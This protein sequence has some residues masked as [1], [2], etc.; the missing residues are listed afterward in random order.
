MPDAAPTAA[1][2]TPTSAGSTP[3]DG[4]GSGQST[5]ERVVALCLHRGFVFRSAEIYGGFRSAYDYGPLGVQLL[6]NIKDQWWRTMVL[7]RREVVGLDAAILSPAAVWEASGHL[8]HFSDPLRQCQNCG[9]RHRGDHLK[10][11][12]TCPDCG[13][14]GAL[15]DARQFNLM[16]STRAGPAADSGAVVYLRPETAQGTYI[17][18]NHVARCVRRPPPFGVAQIGKSFRNE[19]TPGNFVFRT[20]EFEQMEMQYF[21][22]PDRARHWYEHWRDRRL[23][24]YNQLGIADTLLRTRDHRPD[25]LAHYASAACDIEFKFSWGW[26]EL[27]G[28]ANRGDYDLRR[29]SD[30]SRHRLECFDTATQQRY[31][32]HVIEPAAGVARAAMAFLAAA[33]RDEQTPTGPRTVLGLDHRLAPYQVA[34]L[35]LARKPGADPPRDRDIRHA[36]QPLALRLRRHPKHR[37]ALPPPRRDRHTAMRDRRLRHTPRQ[38]RHSTRQRHH[39]PSTRRS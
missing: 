3:A 31:I 37:Q 15:G 7:T 29:H 34:V 17:N 1:D 14:A 39:D 11:A 13:A 9:A 16:F 25:E 22:P 35:P 5:Y 18:F 26:D 33:Y 27:E 19:I 8:D 38:S 24:W 20:R 10:D 6:R 21:V 30:H 32:P 12:D 36:Q 2:T 23:S 4:S 28:I